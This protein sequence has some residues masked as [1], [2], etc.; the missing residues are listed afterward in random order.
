MTIQDIIEYDEGLSEKADYLISPS[1]TKETFNE[2]FNDTFSTELSDGTI[3]D[4]IPNG[5]EIKVEFENKDKYVELMLNIRLSEIDK[6]IELIKQG[7][8]KIVP[9]SL[10]K[11]FTSKELE[12]LICGVKYV[13]VN[14]LKKN[15]E[16][17]STLT[18]E[19]NRIKWFWEII[20]EISE[21]DKIKLIKFC[22]AQER[23]P[24]TQDEYDKLQI[25][26]KIK[27]SMDNHAID[28]FPKADT[29]F[30][31][32]E[33]PKYSDKVN[34]KKKLLQAIHLDNVS[35]NN[36]K[37]NLENNNNIY[38]RRLDNMNNIDNLD[39]ISEEQ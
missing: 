4:L 32:L 6:Q 27:P 36:D 29:C 34:M 33:L 14:L 9:G 38:G 13:N 23:L 11:F 1:L 28:T 35:I 3:V 10:L 15:S 20:N 8:S 17:L 12:R 30:F 25:K 16:Y 24:S 37:V 7:I 39:Y 18:E 19:S 21:E 26:F 2:T 5:R 31:I 22:W